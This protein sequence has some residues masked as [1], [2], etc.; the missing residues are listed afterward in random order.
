MVGEPSAD[1]LEECKQICER[2]VSCVAINWHSTGLMCSAMYDD[3]YNK[4]TQR[5]WNRYFDVFE[6]DVR[7]PFP[8][9]K[10]YAFGVQRRPLS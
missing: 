8:S 2:N 1:T 3:T 9:E 10:H 5:S 6:L 4:L 7:C